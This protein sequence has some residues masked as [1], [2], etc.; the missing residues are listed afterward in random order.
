MKTASVKTIPNKEILR[1]VNS[2]P[3]NPMS[4]LITVH[5]IDWSKFNK[6]VTAHVHANHPERSDKEFYADKRY[7]GAIMHNDKFLIITD[8]ACATICKEGRIDVS[9]YEK[10]EEGFFAIAPTFDCKVDVEDVMECFTGEKKL[11]PDFM[12]ERYQYNS[13]IASNEI[14]LINFLTKKGGK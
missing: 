13:R 2:N 9:I 1:I 11:L 14:A 4:D 3:V 7:S 6:D 12:G 5:I 8:E 10:A